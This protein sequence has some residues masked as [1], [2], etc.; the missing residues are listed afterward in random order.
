ME[1]ATITPH[2]FGKLSSIPVV[3]Q[4]LEKKILKLIDKHILNSEVNKKVPIIALNDVLGFCHETIV[5]LSL[6][7]KL[8]AHSDEFLTEIGEEPIPPF[9]DTFCKDNISQN[10]ERVLHR[11]EFEEFDTNC[12]IET[13]SV[14]TSKTFK[15]A[16]KLMKKGFTKTF[17]RK[18]S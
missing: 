7:D 4:I 10:I 12:D 2:S 11:K 1:L 14:G 3:S 6:G 16:L 9:K 18:I 17:S 15:N 13:T 8:N 5:Q